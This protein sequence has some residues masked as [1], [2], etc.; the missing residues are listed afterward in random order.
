MA[1][2]PLAHDDTFQPDSSP[3][4]RRNHAR[5]ESNW[6]HVM[7]DK[8]INAPAPGRV[9]AALPVQ[10]L[11][12]ELAHLVSRRCNGDDAAGATLQESKSV[13]RRL[14]FI[15]GSSCAMRHPVH[16]VLPCCAVSGVTL[17]CAVLCCA[18]TH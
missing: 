2:H 13:A 3:V 11:K 15:L 7:F 6:V 10:I 4:C 12:V 9:F 16:A 17:C 8:Y 14:E 1:P 5:N 18:A